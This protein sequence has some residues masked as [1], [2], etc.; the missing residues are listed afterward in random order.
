MP[1]PATVPSSRAALDLLRLLAEDAPVGAVEATARRL[2]G[3]DAEAAEH[4]RELAVRVKD[5]LDTR[6]RREEGLGALVETA[7]DLASLRDPGGVLEAIVRRARSLLGTDV[8]YLT[9]F[10]P[11][12]GDTIMRATAG[13]VSAA[14]QSVRLPLGAGLGGLVAQTRRP[15]WT[16]DYL[17]DERF[18]H[19]REID[20]A[21][22][23]E[24]LVAICGTPLL[25]ED[26]FVGVLFASNRVRRPFSVA[27]VSLLGS[28]A[29]LAAVSL[30]QTR[31]LAETRA[32]SAAV[33]QAAE[34]HDRFASVVLEGGG[35][36]DVASTLRDLLGGWVVVLDQDGRRTAEHGEAP[37]AAARTTA[38]ADPLADHPALLASAGTGRLAA[39]DG[40]TASVAT[41]SGERL[42]T[43]VLGGRGDL[44]AGEQRIVERAAVVTALVLLFRRQAAEAE[45]RVR[46]DL[47]SDLLAH[48]GRDG[49]ERLALAERA[50]LLTMSLDDEY[51][52][53]VCHPD[54]PTTTRSLALSAS[55][56]V[57]G[58]GLVAE[59]RGDVVLL[60][61]AHALLAESGPS[62]TA[63][64]LARRLS[65]RG[66]VTVGV[67]GPVVP[68]EGLAAAW[69]EA[70]RTAQALRTLGRAG[71]GAAAA[72]LGFAGL[73]VGERPDVAGYVRGQ[74][75]PVLD[76]DTQRGT[77]LVATLDA[78]FG[79]GG[80]PR[81]AAADLH[82]HVNTVTQRLDRV[83][84][85]L[86]RDWADPTRSLELQLALRLRQVLGPVATEGVVQPN[87]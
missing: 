74:L 86:G 6:K 71:A 60:V 8:A 13:S 75:G 40:V 4:A 9:L 83:R 31:T 43:L 80:S 3:G 70:R 18:R 61:G 2:A 19:T 66:Q 79:N 78:Y 29:A 22:G 39:Q 32:T 48:D 7:R 73:V 34:A 24:G 42:G 54:P 53:A 30:V 5:L 10:D 27:E 16:A 82:V 38:E 64:T 84:A 50:R 58:H 23:E 63:A 51:L 46:T 68:L 62:T 36:G 76:Y 41:A 44:T 11:D 17:D 47:L 21:V 72:D 1:D 45:Q 65:V 12:R 14:F 55:S 20:S 33:Q 59:H 67:A 35:V 87:G 37:P 15:Y 28:L 25:V 26:E 56:L 57:H 52:V 81:R 85:L 69:T 77:E 49:P